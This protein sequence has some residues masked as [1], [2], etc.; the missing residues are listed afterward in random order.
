MAVSTVQKAEIA[1]WI[2]IDKCH[3]P[4]ISYK[5]GQING[6]LPRDLEQLFPRG[7]YVPA[8]AFAT[9]PTYPPNLSWRH[10]SSSSK[11]TGSARSTKS[12]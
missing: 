1:A 9:Y 6:A 3:L 12:L 4:S 2:Y 7:G 8:F 5:N 10:S 11:A